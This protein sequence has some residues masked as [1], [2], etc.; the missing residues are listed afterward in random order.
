MKRYE[1]KNYLPWIM[2][3]TWEHNLFVHFP[4]KKEQLQKLVPQQI[5]LDT[6]DGYCWISIIPYKTTNLH[7]RGMPQVKGMSQYVG[8]NLRTYVTLNG[9]RG[10]YFFQLATNQK[11]SSKMAKI[12]YQLPFFY[13]PMELKEMNDHFTFHEERFFCQYTPISKPFYSKENSIEEFLLERYRFY[14]LSKKGKVKCCDIVHQPWQIQKVHVELYN[15]EILKS[16]GIFITNGKPI[17]H[18]SKKV[19]VKIGPL[20]SLK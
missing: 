9:I 8:L 14:T 10:V 2:K 16:A 4:I 13:S 19:H 1:T 6:F 5:P 3:Q 20:K 12:F 18:Y 15:N 7:F 17:S 11:I